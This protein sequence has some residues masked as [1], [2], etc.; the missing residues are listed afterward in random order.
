MSG[1]DSPRIL[2]ISPQGTVQT[3]MV[4][5]YSLQ[6]F[7]YHK[8][9]SFLNLQPVEVELYSTFPHPGKTGCFMGLKKFSSHIFLDP[10]NSTENQK[11]Y[12]EWSKGAPLIQPHPR[13]ASFD[14]LSRPRHDQTSLSKPD[15]SFLA[16]AKIHTTLSFT[17]IDV[18][19][20]L[21]EILQVWDYLDSFVMFYVT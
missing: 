9:A 3:S 14:P 15:S 16:S 13:Q 19:C 17:S 6:S 18:L 20:H 11:E 10:Q 8:I 5:S 2:H 12:S 4:I 21:S 7:C 1:C